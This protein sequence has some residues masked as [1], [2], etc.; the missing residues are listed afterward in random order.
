MEKLLFG[1]GIK[2]IG[3]KTAKI[4]AK[5]FLNLEK[6]FDLTEEELQQIPDLGPVSAKS[7]FDYFHNEKNIELISELKELGLNF[8]YLG[9]VN[10]DTSSPFFGKTIVLTGTLTKY[11]RKEATEL[12]ENLGAKVAG[13]VSKKTD[14]VIFGAEAGSKLDNAHKL[15]IRT[16]DEEEFE[17]LLQKE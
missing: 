9:L 17:E 8:H 12:L 10:I 11:G 4:L 6:F 14:I 15:G 5:R 2:E 16:M 1:L 13:S 7:I 3:A